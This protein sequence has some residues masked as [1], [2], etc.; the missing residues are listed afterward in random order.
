MTGKNNINPENKSNDTGGL[1]EFK[2]REFF[3]VPGNYFEDLPDRIMDRIESKSNNI[4]S[5]QNNRRWWIYTTAAAAIIVL[6]SITALL[7][8]INGQKE[9]ESFYFAQ[10]LAIPEL[11]LDDLSEAVII[12]YLVR[13][14]ATILNLTIEEL[15]MNSLDTSVKDEDILIYLL[16]TGFSEQD[17]YTF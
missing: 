11:Y 9:S 1:K 16:E 6:I 13:E 12:N 17:L 2:N 15:L 8:Y 14:E 5:L 7:F 4:Y 10:D 3:K